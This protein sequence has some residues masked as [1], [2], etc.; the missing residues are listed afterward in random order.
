MSNKKLI[1]G[2]IAAVATGGFCVFLMLVLV[3]AAFFHAKIVAAIA[4]LV[5][6]LF[7]GCVAVAMIVIGIRALLR[8]G[9]I[10]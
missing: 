2:I 9:R 10:E 8:I 1:Q 4:L 6:L 7:M 5:L 3:V